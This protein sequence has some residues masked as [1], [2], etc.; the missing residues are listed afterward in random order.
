MAYLVTREATGARI[1]LL[2]KGNGEILQPESKSRAHLSLKSRWQK[3][4]ELRPSVLQSQSYRWYLHI[5]YKECAALV[6]N[7]DT[8]L[9]LGPQSRYDRRLGELAGVRQLHNQT[10]NKL[11]NN[12]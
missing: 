7:L 3:S 2:S 1:D 8:K 9:R 6:G 10:D 4:G 11:Q 12:R 5:V